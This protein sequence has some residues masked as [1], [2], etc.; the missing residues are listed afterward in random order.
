M[1]GWLA[2]ANRALP[3][4]QAY[5]ENEDSNQGE[6]NQLHVIHAPAE[7]IEGSFKQSLYRAVRWFDGKIIILGFKFFVDPLFDL[8]REAPCFE[9]LAAV[10]AAIVHIALPHGPISAMRAP[11]LAYLGHE[12]K[13]RNMKEVRGRMSEVSTQ[14]N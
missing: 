13:I 10:D 7:G 8:A 9:K 3:W 4:K 5:H 11:D 6:N 12:A 1:F 14:K 2:A